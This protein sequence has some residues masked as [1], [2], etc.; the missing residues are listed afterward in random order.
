MMQSKAPSFRYY[1]TLFVLS[2]LVAVCDGFGGKNKKKQK[3][4]ALAA[5]EAA[6][7]EVA[8]E[9]FDGH[10]IFGIE[11]STKTLTSSVVLAVLV[12]FALL[13][14]LV[15][16]KSSASD[17]KIGNNPDAEGTV[18]VIIVGCGLPKKGMGW[19]HLTQ[20]LDM[21][22]A[23]LRAVVE[24]FFLNPDL[25][26][27]PPKSW[28]NFVEELQA[29]GVE[30]VAS[31][32]DLSPLDATKKTA[33]LVA[34][35]THDNPKLFSQCI[36]KGCNVIYLEKPGA[37]SVAALEEMK[38]EAVKEGVKVY[39]GY[40]KNVTPYVQNA[41]KVAETT[42]NAHVFFCHNNSYKQKDLPEVFTRNSE[43]ML[44]NMA[45]HEL[46]LLVTFFDVKV[47]TIDKF[48]VNTSKLFSEKLSIWKPGTNLPNPEYLT[49]F[50]R[51]AFKI[52][53][54]AG[55]NVSVMADRCGG[56]VSFA[57]VKDEHGKEVQKFEFPTEEAAKEIEKK[58]AADPDIMPY[59]LVQSD[60]Y[61]E[62][63]NRVIDAILADKEPKGIATIDVAIEALKLAE[64]GTEELNKALSVE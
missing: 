20:L 17:K 57:V 6:A 54:K 12:A 5:E 11:M 45:I 63:K 59:F 39:I 19:Y 1:L 26:K 61:L 53:T 62:L 48:K 13:T 60:D 51:V 14:E 35:R 23:N 58:V 34:G 18:D 55:V 33:A 28:I 50:S 29:K 16:E 25:C 27:D 52:T 36:A 44:K 37:P 4:E 22:T 47:D 2:L 3:E 8:E 7:Q 15:S 30:C 56:N 64:Y 10:V 42:P 9:P 46:A 41:L 31:V 32:D 24:P 49:D 21:P 43:G 38:A 40:N